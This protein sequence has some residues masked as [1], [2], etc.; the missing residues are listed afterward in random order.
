[1]I[2]AALT[3]LLGYLS[4]LAVGANLWR[5]EYPTLRFEMINDILHDLAKLTIESHRIVAI[6]SSNEIS[7]LRNV[8]LLLVAPIPICGIFRNLSSEGR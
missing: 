8:R 2:E 6:Y 3:Q 1:M 5:Q 7:A 4:H